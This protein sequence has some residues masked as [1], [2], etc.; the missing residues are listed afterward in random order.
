MPKEDPRHLRFMTHE[1][2]RRVRISRKHS[3]TQANRR[4]KWQKRLAE[5]R[6]DG[7]AETAAWLDIPPMESGPVLRGEIDELLTIVDHLIDKLE[8]E[9]E[10]RQ[11][12]EQRHMTLGG[13]TR[14]RE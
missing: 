1:Q 4:K 11:V 5:A 6:G 3:R 12:I 7:E 2:A 8:A 13:D 14:R 10:R 9:V